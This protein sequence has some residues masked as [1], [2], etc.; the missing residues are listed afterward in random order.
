MLPME[1]IWP[2]FFLTEKK[3]DV[4]IYWLFIVKWHFKADI[5][6]LHCYISVL[7]IHHSA[8]TN[9]TFLQSGEDGYMKGISSLELLSRQ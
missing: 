8:E 5:C 6:Q 9:Y 3:F 2:D 1:N 7:Y 4:I